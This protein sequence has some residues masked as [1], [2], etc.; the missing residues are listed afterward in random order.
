[1]EFIP[2]ELSILLI[3]LLAI[4]CTHIRIHERSHYHVREHFDRK[5]IFSK[6]KDEVSKH[7]QLFDEG[8]ATFKMALNAFSDLTNEEFIDLMDGMKLFEPLR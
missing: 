6:R 7:N 8:L 3:G 5:E 1:M 2:K 4:E